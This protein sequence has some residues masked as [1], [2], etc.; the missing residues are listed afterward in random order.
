MSDLLTT[1]L[2]EALAAFERH[3]EEEALGVLLE[4]WRSFRDVHL[5][6][7]I[8]RLS[9]RLTDGL[10][11]ADSAGMSMRTSRR[12]VLDLPLMRRA[13]KQA[14]TLNHAPAVMQRLDQFRVWPPHFPD[15]FTVD[16]RLS[17]T[18][19]DAAR[20]RLASDPA[21]GPR[22]FQM[23]EAIADPRTLDGIERLQQGSG[24]RSAAF[25]AAAIPLLQQIKSRRPPPPSAEAAARLADW[26]K[27]LS[28]REDL[29]ERHAPLRE[30]LLGRVYAA[31]E[32]MAARL[33][34]A[35]HLQETGDPRGEF[36]S[37][38][39]LPGASRARIEQL[40]QKYAP[41]WEAPL[42]PLVQRESTRFE[43]GFPVAARLV[44]RARQVL[45]EPGTAWRTVRELDTAGIDT[46][47]LAKWL[48]HP[49]LSN[50]TTLRRVGPVL[51]RELVDRESPVRNLSLV[52]ALNP[53][54]P[55]L[56]DQLAL[57]PRLTRVVLHTTAPTDVFQ[58][59]RSP[60][61]A[62]LER[63]EARAVNAWTL[64]L[65]PGREHPLRATLVH[66]G[67]AEPF[68]QVLRGAL[69]FQAARLRIRGVH[70]ADPRGQALLRAAVE[71]HPG[72][73][74]S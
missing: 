59:A 62:R 34:L 52:G 69:G 2:G 11:L 23:L 8:D 5:A 39:L 70:R 19:L 20:H 65:S 24:P 21:V 57:L 10:S 37:S 54:H 25:E 46:R 33:V 50:V 74:W 48:S 32:D 40:L 56:L 47:E 13:L 26:S 18:L 45:S 72:V 7:L 6:D 28:R 17:Y 67:Q 22:I 16:P 49:N 58:C 53:A 38:Q 66:G 14:L 61:A 36:I 3:D 27:A 71:G 1:K 9:D 15:A 64:V 31:P 44:S 42:G 51:A 68:A 73:T 30:E 35:D 12:K 60:L 55:S 4:T 29:E 41:W 63:F 43:R